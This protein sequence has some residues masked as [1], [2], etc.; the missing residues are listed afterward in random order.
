MGGNRRQPLAEAAT[1]TTIGTIG[2][3][4]I[5]TAVARLA[6]A[7]GYDVVLSNSRGPRP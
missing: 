6:L 7:A 1:M 3:G 5:G 4:H 2:A